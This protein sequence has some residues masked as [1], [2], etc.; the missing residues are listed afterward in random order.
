MEQSGREKRR[1]ENAELRCKIDK[2]I[3]DGYSFL[4][5]NLNDLD[6]HN[7]HYVINKAVEELELDNYIIIQLLE[8]YIIQILKSKIVFLKYIEE[9]EFAKLENKSLDYLKLR[10]L[11]HKNLGVARNLRIEDAQ[12]LLTILMKEDDLEY[13]KIC[14]KAL[15]VSAVKINPLCAYETLSLID[16][17]NSL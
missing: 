3:Y 16:V 13:L 6:I 9:L 15:E 7:Y 11:A 5:E 8:D 14:S 10:N 4:K 17:K 2:L 12:K 1:P